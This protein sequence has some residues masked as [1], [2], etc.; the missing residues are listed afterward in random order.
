M[1]ISG[2]IL[3]DWITADDAGAVDTSKTRIRLTGRVA[4]RLARSR[5]RV[6]RLAGAALGLTRVVNTDTTTTTEWTA[7]SANTRLAGVAV[8]AAAVLTRPTRTP[9]RSARSRCRVTRLAGAARLG[10][11]SIADASATRPTIDFF[12]GST[13]AG[14]TIWT[15]GWRALTCRRI[16]KSARACLCYTCAI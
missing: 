12:T 16:A 1:G 13:D 9:G 3:A 11:T 5:C 15:G 2:A 6:A 4:G 10:L 14:L 8:A 7:E